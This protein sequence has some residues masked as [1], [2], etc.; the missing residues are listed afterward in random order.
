MSSIISNNGIIIERANS[1]NKFQ[2]IITLI[3]GMLIGTIFLFAA[4]WVW[5]DNNDDQFEYVI[6]KITKVKPYTYQNKN[7]ITR[8]AFY[9]TVKYQFNGRNQMIILQS[10][11][12]YE[13]GD[14]I[15]L[16]VERNNPENANVIRTNHNIFM[17]GFLCFGCILMITCLFNLH[18]VSNTKMVVY[19]TGDFELR[20]CS[21]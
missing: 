17:T 6:G 19:P 5:Y 13:K 11:T 2:A 21:A 12:K 18:V 7:N 10:K 8:D 1:Y 20:Q 14:L 4:M 15:D 3:Y 16:S 9:L